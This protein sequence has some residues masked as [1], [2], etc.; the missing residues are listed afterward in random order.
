MNRDAIG[1]ISEGLGAVAVLVTLGY[2]AIQVRC[3]RNEMA[4]VATQRRLQTARDCAHIEELL[5]GE[6]HTFDH[7]LRMPYQPG[8]IFRFWM[9]HQRDGLNPDAAACIDNLLGPMSQA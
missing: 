4:R 7:N 6:R 1:A 5:P 3:G 8:T 9:D 2:L